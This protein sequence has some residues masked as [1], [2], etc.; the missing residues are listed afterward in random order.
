MAASKKQEKRYDIAITNLDL[1]SLMRFIALLLFCLS[2]NL[3]AKPNIVTN[4]KPLQ[5]ILTSLKMSLLSN[6]YFQTEHLRII[7]H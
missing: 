3:I 6:L 2:F 7:M 4:I 1:K 5:L